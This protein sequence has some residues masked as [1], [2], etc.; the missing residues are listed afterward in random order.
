M[1][2]AYVKDLRETAV[3]LEHMLHSSPQ[4]FYYVKKVIGRMLEQEREKEKA[5]KGFTQ[6]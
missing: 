1:N 4:N 6:Q 2:A 5:A 3:K